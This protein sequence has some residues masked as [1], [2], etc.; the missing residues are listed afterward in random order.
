ME[1][2]MERDME[3]FFTYLHVPYVLRVCLSVCLLSVSVLPSAGP[4][5]WPE[6]LNENNSFPNIDRTFCSHLLLI[7]AIPEVC[8]VLYCTNL[9][10]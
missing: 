8:T 1:R 6:P 2:G 7:L 10:T 3:R 4:S 5:L 9:P